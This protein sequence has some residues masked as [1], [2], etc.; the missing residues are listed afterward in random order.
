MYAGIEEQAFKNLFLVS[1]IFNDGRLSKI[2]SFIKRLLLYLF[3]IN[4]RKLNILSLNTNCR[5]HLLTQN[6]ALL[7]YNLVVRAYYLFGT[8]LW[9]LKNER[10]TRKKVVQLSTECCTTFARKLYNFF[11]PP[12]E[13]LVEGIVHLAKNISSSEQNMSVRAKKNGHVI[14]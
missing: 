1:L 5:I 2:I 7:A 10:L 14:C 13:H 4:M 3:S 6:N 8:N 12:T 9:L 11:S